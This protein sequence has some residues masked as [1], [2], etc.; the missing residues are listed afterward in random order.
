MG[1]H[2][3]TNFVNAKRIRSQKMCREWQLLPHSFLAPYQLVNA[4]VRLVNGLRLHDH[5]TSAEIDLHWLP[6]E[7]R[8]QYKLCLLVHHALAGRAPT[9][10]IDL[11]QPVAMSSRHA[12]PWS[13]TTNSLFVPRTRLQF[14][15]RAFRVSAPKA[16]NQL[17]RDVRCV[18]NTNTFKKKKLKTRKR[19]NC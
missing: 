17:P 9:Y 18:D 14:G 3:D 7:A 6:V 15:E 8:L 1:G 2:N 12:T 19:V 10:V 5:V 11:L 4:A 13:E 16:W